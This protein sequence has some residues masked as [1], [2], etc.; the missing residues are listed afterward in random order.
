MRIGRARQALMN[1]T[2]QSLGLQSICPLHASNCAL[3]SGSA[4]RADSFFPSDGWLVEL[5]VD[6]NLPRRSIALP[7]V[8]DAPTSGLDAS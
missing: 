8:E 7:A 2:L 1:S 3:I 6:R 4:P 5:V